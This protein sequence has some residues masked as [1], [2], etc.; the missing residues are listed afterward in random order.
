MRIRSLQDFLAGLVF[1]GLGGGFFLL[2]QH[3]AMGKAGRMGP[4]YFPSLLG[5]TLALI[6]A[7]VAVRALVVHGPR[8]EAVQWRPLLLILGSLAAFAG[9][10]QVYGLIL[11]T[12]TLI[13]IA[14]I[15][16][17]EVRKFEVPG[18]AAGTAVLSHAVFVLG[19]GLPIKVWP[20]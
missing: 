5:G 12:A 20:V 8:I 11:A 9:L 6:G 16:T 4:G 15:A 17:D 19:L 13:V 2:S 10:I 7:V 14:C 3:Y 1:V 18:L